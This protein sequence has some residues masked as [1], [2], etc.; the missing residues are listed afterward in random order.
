MAPSTMKRTALEKHGCP[1]ARAIMDGITFYVKNYAFHFC[2]V[3]FYRKISSVAQ[4]IL[5]MARRGRRALHFF[6]YLTLRD[7]LLVGLSLPVYRLWVT[8]NGAAVYG[9]QPSPH[10]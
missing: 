8:I 6:L 1:D 3:L 5:R 2:N 10:S 9:L 7:L 4:I